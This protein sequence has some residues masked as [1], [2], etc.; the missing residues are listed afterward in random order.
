MAT[1]SA[2]L[3]EFNTVFMVEG[4][5]ASTPGSGL[6]VA[7]A[8]PGGVFAWKDD[9]GNEYEIPRDA[10]EL[11]LDPTGLSTVTATDVQGAIGEL[12][13]AIG[14]GGIPV[15]IIDAAGDLIVGT[16]ADTAG[17]LAIGAAGGH[18]SRINGALAWDSG[19]SNP[20]SA[21][22]GDRFW[23]TDIHGG[24]PIFYDGTRWLSQQMFSAG[25]GVTASVSAAVRPVFGPAF[26]GYDVFVERLSWAAYV[27][28]TNTGSAY[29]TA[30]LQ[31]NVLNTWTNVGSAIDTSAAS[32][33]DWVQVNTDVDTVV[34]T[35]NVVAWGVLFDKVST[36][37]PLIYAATMY[38]RLVI[39]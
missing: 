14:A 4:A 19:T 2:D 6:I 15:T 7:Y 18:L 33:N 24:L 8:K 23:R 21:A 11:S 34:T 10:S 17:R 36:P 31:R 25:A 22:A 5:A 1:L 9:A 12:D 28:T 13:A 29:W 20:G 16:A 37:G 27:D 26:G 30:Q 38:Y 32:A 3:N 35:A 39:P